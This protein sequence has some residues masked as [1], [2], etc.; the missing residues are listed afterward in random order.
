MSRRAVAQLQDM[1]SRSAG[2]AKLTAAH[3]PTTV[4]VLEHLPLT[5]GGKPDKHALATLIQTRRGD[6]VAEI[7]GTT[8]TRSGE[9]TE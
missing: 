1:A 9:G 2:V 8:R 3:V 6:R 5:P 7:G 4:D